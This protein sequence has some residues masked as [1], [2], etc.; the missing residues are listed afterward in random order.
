[1]EE[2]KYSLK[3]LRARKNWTQRET[4]R[5]LGISEQTYNAWEKDISGVSISK[6]MA[7]ASLFGVRIGQI[8]FETKHENNSCINER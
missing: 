8:F 1:M 5:K 2:M 4:A 3:E 6:V 7:V